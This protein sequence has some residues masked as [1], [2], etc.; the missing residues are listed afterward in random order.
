ME[1]FLSALDVDTA[2]QFVG[3]DTT[4]V[5]FHFMRVTIA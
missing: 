1:V 2:L 5:E 4:P 3:C